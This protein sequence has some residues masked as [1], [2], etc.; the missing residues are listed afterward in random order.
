MEEGTILNKE[1]KKNTIINFLQNHSGYT[2]AA[3]LAELLS[4]SS[5]SVYRLINEIN[6]AT[7]NKKIHSEKGK[8]FFIDPDFNN[9]EF[10]TNIISKKA[11]TS[12]SPLERR[13]EIIKDLL[14]NSPDPLSVN[15]IINK[16][17]ISESMLSIDEKYIT[18]NIKNLHL[19]LIRKDRTLV[20]LGTEN[21]IR[22]ALI[23]KMDT[24]YLNIE[25]SSGIPKNTE[26]KDK[27]FVYKQINTIEKTL[28]INIP[29]P[30]NINIF[31]HLYILILRLRKH[32]KYVKQNRESMKFIDKNLNKSFYRVCNLI[33]KNFEIYLSSKL[34]NVEIDYLYKYLISYRLEHD[35]PSNNNNEYEFSNEIINFTD[36]LIIPMEKKFDC[37]FSNA[38]FRIDLMKHIRPM[39]NRLENNILIKNSLLDQIKFEYSEVFFQTSYFS[40]LLINK[41]SEDEIGFLTLYFAREIERNPKKVKTLITCTTGIGTSELLRV[42]IEKNIPEIE[43]IDVVSSDTINN[44]LVNNID[45][46]ISTVTIKDFN[47]VPVVVVSAMFNKNDQEKIKMLIPKLGANY[48]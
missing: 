6:S 32:G 9:L 7:D 40:K 38:K 26:E 20:I 23:Q 33:I 24:L 21:N 11:K 47:Q 4:I 31:S 16:F 30:Y 1:D 5:K 2:K 10:E 44:K 28:N 18:E 13:N 35:Q 42:K 27:N 36:N 43:I 41:L 25:K 8:G 12:M 48:E 39:F 29:Y 14:I 19:K 46:I 22:S 45:L 15:H 3:V 37:S 34:P 17:Y